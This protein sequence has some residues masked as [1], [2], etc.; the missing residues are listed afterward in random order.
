MPGLVIGLTLALG[1]ALVVRGLNHQKTPYEDTSGLLLYWKRLDKP[2][3]Y[4][5]TTGLAVGVVA[6]FAGWFA[7]LVIAP[8]TLTILTAVFVDRRDQQD[9]AKMTAL[10]AWMRELVDVL[11]SGQDVSH[12]IQ[13]TVNTAHSSIQPAVKELSLG[14][15]WGDREAAFKK[16]Q[17]TLRDSTADTATVSLRLALGSS[18]EGLSQSL[19]LC[20]DHI[21]REIGY[22]EEI[23]NERSGPRTVMRILFGI[24]T[25]VL[26]AS[27]VLPSVRHFYSSPSGQLTATVLAVIYCGML[28]AS[29][30]IMT[31]PAPPRITKEAAGL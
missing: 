22:R 27:S 9:I 24:A 23:R 1:I 14:L 21:K 29:R 10:G 20:A 11:K 16:F 18:A 28:L 13:L 30:S 7:G 4:A 12:A 2:I 8:M 3:R 25:C 31:S 5:A 19:E 15:Q 26:A 6:A 17:D